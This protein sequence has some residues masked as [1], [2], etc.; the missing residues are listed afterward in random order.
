MI[1]GGEG[2][3][4]G[5]KSLLKQQVQ[6]YMLSCAFRSALTSQLPPRTKEAAEPLRSGT[7]LATLVGEVRIC[8]HT[9]SPK[10]PS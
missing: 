1:A 3:A 8:Q 6:V 5:N 2:R 9:L 10:N 7:S 4:S